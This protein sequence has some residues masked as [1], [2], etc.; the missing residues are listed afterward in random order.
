MPNLHRIAG[1]V[2]YSN[3]M[4]NLY[5]RLVFQTYSRQQR[6]SRGGYYSVSVAGGYFIHVGGPRR[7]KTIG[8]YKSAIS[9][10]SYTGYY[11]SSIG[12]RETLH[13]VYGGNCCIGCRLPA[14]LRRG[15]SEPDSKRYVVPSGYSNAGFMPSWTA[16]R[17]Y[18]EA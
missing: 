11:I 8:L 12:I 16:R 7:G 18:I 2:Y 10:V 4:T 13:S 15:L 6:D 3:V 5:H 9:H 1:L 17:T 14:V